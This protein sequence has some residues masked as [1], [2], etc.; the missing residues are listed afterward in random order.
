LKVK[1]NKK[2]PG[3]GVKG[4]GELELKFIRRRALVEKTPSVLRGRLRD[5]KKLR[6]NQG[7]KS[8]KKVDH[9]KNGGL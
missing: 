4:K 7:G 2:P 9:L 1:N 6:T 3:E 8:K 5:P